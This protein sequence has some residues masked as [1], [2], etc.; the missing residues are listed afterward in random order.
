[1]LSKQKKAF[2]QQ[3]SCFISL[4]AKHWYVFTS[5]ADFA[6]QSKIQTEMPGRP[7]VPQTGLS[8]EHHL[9]SVQAGSLQVFDLHH[10]LRENHILQPDAYTTSCMAFFPGMIPADGSTP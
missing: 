2:L 5:A 4:H 9:L 1:M 10:D 6:S 3:T 8:S 7:C